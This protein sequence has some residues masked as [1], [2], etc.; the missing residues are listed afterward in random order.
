L[1]ILLKSADGRWRRTVTCLA[2]SA[3][4]ASDLPLAFPV[5]AMTRAEYEA[6]QSRDENGFRAAIE[7]IT[8]KGLQSAIAG[9]DYRAVVAEEWH[10]GLLDDVIDR[11]VDLAIGQIRDESSWTQL[12]QSL[13]SRE[14]A[15]ELATAA[16]ERVYK[17][18]AMHKALEGLVGGVGKA[19]AKRIETA[20]I[21]TAEPAMQCTRAFLGPRY[22]S[23]IAR[24]VAREA[25]KEYSVDP[26]KGSAEISSGQIL[27]ESSEGI[28]GAV[29]LLVRRQLANMASRVGQRVIGSVLGRLVS[30]VAGGV[31]LVLLA[32]DVWDFRYGVLPI[33]ATEMKSPAIKD[34][35]KDE[36]TKSIAEQIGENLKE[37]SA[38]TADRVV[39]IWQDFRR[40]HAK[41]IE[42]V[43]KYDDFKSFIEAVSANEMARLDEVV[44][45]ILAEEG[46]AGV[47]RRL[48]DGTLHE[49]VSVVPAEAI[50]IARE[51]RS[52][53]NAFQ[54][55]AIAGGSLAKVL[56]YEIHR[57]AKP[58][59][60]S[61]ASLQRL[62][63]LEDRLAITR[64]AALPTNARE[65]LFELANDD[66]KGL[67]RA[68][69]ESELISLARY[70]TGLPKPASERLLRA[71]AHRPARMQL[72]GRA[73]VR[74]AVLSSHDAE[75]AVSM[76]LQSD[77]L[78]D[79]S[80]VLEHFQ[81]AF[82][83]KVSP[84]LV[85]EKHPLAV[86]FS[87]TVIALVL[88]AFCRLLF[89]R[90]PRIIVQSRAPSARTT[91]G[92]RP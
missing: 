16:A 22:G 33:V 84:I 61:K 47:L 82:D 27:A 26:A 70:W 20:T 3:L 8:L 34:K 19:I 64:L 25:G 75:A 13:G 74:N 43:G 15:Q 62:L 21:D 44:G 72:L 11:Q 6:C 52:I 30:I 80:V 7:D 49:A 60:F 53:E 48:G 36:L 17:S 51:S 2:V 18:D 90:R 69:T 66:L 77:S 45:L 59:S 42:L 40:S 54:W 41:V 73:N 92:R 9:I 39:D 79:P 50:E 86:I 85:W 35:V 71:V 65:P 68:L 58:D 55:S 23:T 91:N 57:R 89:G 5:M 10:H 56:D 31:G 67:A 12:L 29:V 76:L 1:G 83:G 24:V 28:A 32:K 4:I 88:L 46:E 87:A 37:V 81:L 14:K 78:P 38:H 63:S